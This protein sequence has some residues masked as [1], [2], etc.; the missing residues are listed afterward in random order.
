MARL[1]PFEPSPTVAVAVSGGPDSMALCLLADRWARRQGGSVLALTVDH[2]LR[3]GSAEEAAT[4]A[5]WLADRRIV[6]RVLPWRGR[7]AGGSV[8]AAARTARYG[9]LEQAC[10]EAGI[11][12]LLLAHTLDDQAETVLLRLSRG[13]GVDGLAAMAGVRETAN[14][15]LLRPLLDAGK[16]RL[17]A[18]CRQFGQDWIEDPSNSAPQFARGR[19]R[20]VSAALEQ[21]GLTADRLADTARRAS[22]ARSALDGG[23]AELLGRAAAVYPEGYATLD[24]ARLM[25]A[26]EEL[27]LRALSRCLIAFGA[28]R[29]IGRRTHGD[30]ESSSAG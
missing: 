9:L 22:R 24:R 7:S 29:M 12:H 27:A 17:R 28:G 23:A 3:T 11:L 15:R 13:S 4:V 2:R 21:E 14:I 25:D 18:T 30:A 20:R 8:Q 19:L 5:A 10:G 1:G 26:P 6:H 16:P